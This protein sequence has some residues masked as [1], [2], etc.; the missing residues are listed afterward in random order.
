ML[1]LVNAQFSQLCLVVEH[2][3]TTLTFQNTVTAAL[4]YESL[5]GTGKI[6]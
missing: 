2:A 3:P 6:I 4:L 1:T 5:C